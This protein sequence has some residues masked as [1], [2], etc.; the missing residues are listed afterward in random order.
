MGEMRCDAMGISSKIE[1]PP[2]HCWCPEKQ[3]EDS[4]K[5]RIVTTRMTEE[6]KRRK[7]KKEEKSKR[8]SSSN[9]TDW[10]WIP[11]RR[12]PQ[13]RKKRTKRRCLFMIVFTLTSSVPIRH[14]QRGKCSCEREHRIHL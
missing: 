2:G 13:G 8:N 14:V 11:A 7:K 6:K 4:Q 10:P 5:K 1:T 3:W 9:K 12:A